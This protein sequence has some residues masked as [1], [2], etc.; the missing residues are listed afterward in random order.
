[1]SYWDRTPEGRKR[2]RKILSEQGRGIGGNPPSRD[3]CADIY[4]YGNGEGL[5]E[6]IGWR[7]AHALASMRACLGVLAFVAV[8]GELRAVRLAVDVAFQ[9]GRRDALRRDF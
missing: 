5:I 1:M 7:R 2:L 8:L 6:A 3:A 4:N 9:D